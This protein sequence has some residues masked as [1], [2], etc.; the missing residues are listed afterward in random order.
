MPTRHVDRAGRGG[1]TETD[2]DTIDLNE[3]MDDLLRFH[4]GWTPFWPK[5]QV[6]VFWVTSRVTRDGTCRKHSK[7][8]V[9]SSTL[10]TRA[11]LSPSA[12]GRS[13][14]GRTAL[15]RAKELDG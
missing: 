11:S 3:R 10:P 2:Q 9:T 14:K 1:E 4:A 13:Q 6:F 7:S 15:A 12:N 5:V 8:N